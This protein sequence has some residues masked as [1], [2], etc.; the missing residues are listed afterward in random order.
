MS[1]TLP[2]KPF[3]QY[4]D[5]REPQEHAYD[6]RVGTYTRWAANSPSIA[7]PITAATNMPIRKPRGLVVSIN[8]SENYFSL[9]KRGI[10]GTYH[11]V[12][13]AHLGRYL[14]EFDFRY[15]NRIKLGVDDAMRAADL[16]GVKASGSPMTS[17]LG[18]RGSHKLPWTPS[19]K[20]ERARPHARQRKRWAKD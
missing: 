3:D 16:E 8:A 19:D 2:R 15:S 1:Q 4:H 14:A 5:A 20:L 10:D 7:A 17:L 11:S 18:I 12:S 9:L 13:G 6:R